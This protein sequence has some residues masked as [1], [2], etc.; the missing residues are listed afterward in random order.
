[1]KEKRHGVSGLFHNY[2]Y[3]V[4][5]VADIFILLAFLLLG[6]LIGNVATLLVMAFMKGS[7]AATQY[8]TLVSYPL[9][10]IPAMMYARYKSLAGSTFEPGFKMDSGSFSPLGGAFCAVL[11]IFGTL[12]VSFVSEPVVSILPE[13]PQWLK[14]A[15]ES[16][17]EGN[18]VIDFI[19]VSIFAPLFEEWLCRGMVLRGLLN[20]PVRSRDGS[21]R[22]GMK[23][24]WAI[25]I[26]AAFFALIHMNPWQAIPAFIMGCLFGYV[27]YKTGSLKLTMLMHFTNNTFAVI[28]SHIDRFSDVDGW[29]EVLPTVTYWALFAFCAAMILYVVSKFH[30]VVSISSQGSCERVSD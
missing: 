19:C 23:P 25:V 28:V 1:M 7:A 4:P 8:A 24:A 18:F 16:M 2:T 5:G 3:Y 12:A 21:F 15:L 9:M 22:P 17:T 20:R 6:A 27:Y 14:S 13:M 11:C 26:S 30:S 10:F 29:N